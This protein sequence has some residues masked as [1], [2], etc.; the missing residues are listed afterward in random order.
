MNM[1]IVLDLRR[2]GLETLTGV[3]TG[4]YYEKSNSNARKDRVDRAWQSIDQL[5]LVLAAISVETKSCYTDR[6][7]CML[8]AR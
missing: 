7:R 5:Q 8:F 6:H 2:E 3:V 1:I 4:S